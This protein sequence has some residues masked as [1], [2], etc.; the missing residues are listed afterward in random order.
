MKI[1][2]SPILPSGARSGNGH[3]GVDRT[4]EE[5]VIDDDLEEDLPEEFAVILVPA[6]GCGPAALLAEALDF[7]HGHALDLDIVE[8]LHHGIQLW[9]LDNRHHHLHQADSLRFLDITESS[10]GG[11]QFHGFMAAFRPNFRHN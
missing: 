6:V 4:F 7:G 5:V 2:P 10:G 1:L 3:D 9:W 11:P 8:D